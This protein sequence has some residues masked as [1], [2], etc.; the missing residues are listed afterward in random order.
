MPI[1]LVRQIQAIALCISLCLVSIAS[2]AMSF[3][4]QERCI[5]G[6]NPKCQTMILAIGQ[7]DKESPAQFK[8]FSKDFPRGTWVAISSPGGNLIGGM[9]LGLAIR[10]LG[11]NTV[12][13]NSDY[14]PPECLSACAY[15]FLGGVSRKLTP[16]SR[17]GLHQFRGSD[18][19]IS[20]EETQKISATMAKYV[21]AMGADRRLLDYAELTTSDKITTLTL[22]QAQ[23]LKVDTGGQSSY[24]RWHLEATADAKLLALNSGLLTA[25]SQIPVTLGVLPV[26][27]KAKESKDAK[28]VANNNPNK[29]VLAC[30]I[31]YKSADA[32]TFANNNPHS[33]QIGST[34]YPLVLVGTWQEKTGGYQATFVMPNPL[35]E[36]L[37]QSPE[38]A[39][40]TL[41]AD[42]IKPPKSN[43]SIAS[44]S[45]VL[46]YFGVG[47]FK[48]SVQ[49]LLKR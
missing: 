21:D 46:T 37:L 47:N 49:A 23:V 4:K 31:Y 1:Q 26:A 29:D 5:D 41:R 40:I 11:F 39:V 16:G 45:P 44:A 24:P 3:E 48:T 20:A 13:G 38:D 8:T 15:T 27:L 9:Q 12:I 25:G 28:I 33:I 10:E 36:A 6:L 14:S 17:Y 7:I 42:F 32:A 43:T 30:L 34:V 19:A 2:W 18:K 22:A 35:V